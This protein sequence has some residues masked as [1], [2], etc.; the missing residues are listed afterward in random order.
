[1]TNSESRQSKW[2]FRFFTIWTGQQFSIIG[3][4]VAQFAL[5]W[6]LT[7]TTGSATI[8]A[9]ATLVAMLPGVLF[10]PFAGAVVD[11]GNRRKI[12]IVADGLV[13]LAA[14]L[15]AYL[16]WSGRMQV[17]HVYIIMLARSIGGMFHWPAMH[18]STSLM[19]PKEQLSRVAG[20]NQTMRGILDIVSPPLGALLL[21]LMPLHG[22]MALDVVT[23]A[24]AI[25]PLFFVAIPQPERRA[26]AI[27]TGGKPSLWQ[28][29]REGLRYV[30]SWPG[31]LLLLTMATLLNFL[32]N[33]AFTLMPLLVSKYFG[34]E[35]LQLGWMHSGWGLGIVLGGLT[36][37]VWGGFRRR[38]V[39]S[40]IGVIGMGL[41]TLAIGLTPATLFVVALVGISVAGFMNPIAN[42]PL[43]AIFQAATAPEMQ[44]RVFT[45]IGS[46]AAAMSPLG[47]AIA[48]PVADAIGVRAWFIM[49]GLACILMGAG[50]LFV[51]AIM[52]LEENGMSHQTVQAARA[53]EK[54]EA[55]A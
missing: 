9:T 33:P 21:S 7:K 43:H 37:S 51:P 52:H 20:I 19:V 6:W 8:L 16:F 29:V 40:L 32:L 2:Q 31:L 23:A 42:G 49:G 25:A 15:L 38:I 35:A 46:L 13:A 34:G 53:S 4:M 24:I 11:R 44:G 30:S 3:S 26:L 48:G 28:D 5:V 17:W 18:A 1:M 47:M 45:L 55:A 54:S 36:L 41:G 27:A 22:I 50:A 12:M 14:A 10:G 39:T